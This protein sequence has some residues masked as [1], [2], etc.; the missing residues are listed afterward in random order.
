[1]RE[2][3]TREK[4]TKEAELRELAMRAR[5]ERGGG[6]AVPLAARTEGRSALSSEYLPPPPPMRHGEDAQ[7]L[8]GPPG[9]SPPPA[10]RGEREA[11]EASIQNLVPIDH[12]DHLAM[13]G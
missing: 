11:P 7:Q 9:G 12:C 2:Q 6:A 10:A 1:M 4:E 3:K 5:M 8:P 13:T